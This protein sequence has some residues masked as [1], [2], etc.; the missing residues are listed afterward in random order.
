MFCSTSSSSFLRQSNNN[1]NTVPGW[2]IPRECAPLIKSNSPGTTNSS[3]AFSAPSLP[4]AHPQCE[5]THVKSAAGWSGM[6]FVLEAL[7]PE[8]WFWFMMWWIRKLIHVCVS[9]PHIKGVVDGSHPQVSGHPLH[10]ARRV[11]GETIYVAAP[12]RATD[13]A[14]F[15]PYSPTSRDGDSFPDSSTGGRLTKRDVGKCDRGRSSWGEESVVGRNP[16]K[17]A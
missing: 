8:L 7:T 3:S 12:C 6:S 17:S 1:N 16:C 15:K 13:R 14:P 11:S 9:W 5:R 10:S 2:I 4:I